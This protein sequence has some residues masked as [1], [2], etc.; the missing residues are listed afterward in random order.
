MVE[1]A[2]RF[3]NS[4]AQERIARMRR[5]LVAKGKV[6]KSVMQKRIDDETTDHNTIVKAKNEIA[7]NDP[8]TRIPVKTLETVEVMNQ[9]AYYATVRPG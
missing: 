8:K 7:Q 2:D 5:K 3:E 4:K 1:C 6:S 9:F